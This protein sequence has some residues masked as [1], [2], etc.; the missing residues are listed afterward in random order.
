[1]WRMWKAVMRTESFSDVEL[2]VDRY[3]DEEKKRMARL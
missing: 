2:I 3:E 1:M